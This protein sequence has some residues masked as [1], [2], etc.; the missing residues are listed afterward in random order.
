M[1]LPEVFWA[2]DEEEQG[3]NMT[4]S[5]MQMFQRRRAGAKPLPREPPLGASGGFKGVWA[6]ADS[7]TSEHPVLPFG[8]WEERRTCRSVQLACL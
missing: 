2:G 1:Q 6:A 4:K 5:Q 8:P 3:W 7:G